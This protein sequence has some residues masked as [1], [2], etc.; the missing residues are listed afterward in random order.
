MK[1][2]VYIILLPSLLSAELSWDTQI[3]SLDIHSLQTSAV[4]EFHCTNTGSNTVEVISVKTT[5]A[6]LTAV[7]E[8]NQ[9]SPDSQSKI[10]A[11]FDL[12]DRV[13]PQR[14]SI[15]VRD[16]ANPSQPVFL[17]VEANIPESYV[18]SVSRLNWSLNSGNPEPQVC[19]LSNRWENPIKLISAVS[20][21]ESFTVELKEIVEGYEYEVRVLP[22]NISVPGFARISIQAECPESLTESRSYQFEAG[23][24]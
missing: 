5:C 14:K 23:V 8:T 11:T 18:L 22:K 19:R 2:W 21:S 6:C 9:I 20:S 17:Y 10:T 24:R 4:A 1:H 13:G 12:K 7:A 15:A 3:V 16:S